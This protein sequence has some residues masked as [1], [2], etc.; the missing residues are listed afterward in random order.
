MREDLWEDP[1]K[2]IP[3]EEK[4]RCKGLKR[5]VGKVSVSAPEGSGWDS[6]REWDKGSQHRL[7]KVL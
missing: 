5:P 4:V 1:G 2:G 7:H 3:G 6:R